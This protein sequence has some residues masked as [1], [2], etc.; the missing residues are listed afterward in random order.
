MFKLIILFCVSAVT[1]E[2]QNG[3]QITE[4]KHH[5]NISHGLS[6]C[7]HWLLLIAYS[8]VSISD[9]TVGGWMSHYT[10]FIHMLLDLQV[11]FFCSFLLILLT[12]LRSFALSLVLRNVKGMLLSCV[13]LDIESCCTHSFIL[14]EQHRSRNS[15]G[16]YGT[17]RNSNGILMTDTV[18]SILVDESL[19]QV[20]QTFVGTLK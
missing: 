20:V 1:L 14:I 8:I 13:F 11:L 7:D 16:A 19:V 12:I 3:F 18:R 10:L 4:T 5:K 6:G 17:G 2:K 9:F 15:S